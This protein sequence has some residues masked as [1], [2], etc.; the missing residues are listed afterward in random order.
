MNHSKISVRYAKA[1]FLASRDN[2]VLDPVSRDMT[3]IA[4]M[5]HE[6]PSFS[7][8]LENPVIGNKQKELLF[9]KT[10]KKHLNALTFRFILLLLKNNR[11]VFL[12]DIA[13]VFTGY[14]KKEKGITEALL[15]SAVEINEKL[16]EQLTRNLQQQLKTEIH[17]DEEINPELIGGFILKV[18]DEQYDAS[19]RRQLQNI[20]QELSK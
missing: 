12:P 18:E 11:E 5:F 10:F 6:N 3:L 2:N 13:R 16:K 15:S 4:R 19:V 9:D 14:Y 1:L 7:Q 20:R 17:L 8:L